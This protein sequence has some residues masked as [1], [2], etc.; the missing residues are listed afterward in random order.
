MKKIYHLITQSGLTR[1]SKVLLY[2]SN[3]AA[4]EELEYAEDVNT[5]D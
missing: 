1:H 5:F 2:V 4:K 3:Y